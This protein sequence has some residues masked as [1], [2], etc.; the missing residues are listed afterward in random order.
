MF[1]ATNLGALE[2]YRVP[3]DWKG[4]LSD[5]DP[6]DGEALPFPRPETEAATAGDIAEIDRL[7]ELLYAQT[8]YALLI[9]L[10][11]P[12][13]S[14]KDGTIRRVFSPINP[15][16]AV[17]TSFK[18]PTPHELAHDF[19]WRIHKAVPPA[20]MIG[21][22]NRSHYEDVLVPRVHRLVPADRIEARYRQINAFEQHLSEN[23]V[24]ILKFYPHISKK[25]QKAR[26]EARLRDPTKRWKFNPDDLAERKHW[27]DYLSA[28]E[29]ALQR[30][31]T[32]WAPW[33]IVPADHKW[34]RNAVV[35]RI[36]R[37]TLEALDLTYPSEMPGLDK[38]RI[39]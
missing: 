34:Y 36:V 12:D 8:K 31:S 14:G 10:Q 3:A 38:V 30:C 33:F 37:A 24:T 23:D 20:G 32:Q 19:L 21:I 5:S 39:D 1:P 25:E 27:S 22:F 35:A 26:L 9:V 29:I 15:L 11:G 6:R 2:R 16:G 28:Y 13:T 17:A 4:K 7:Q 18:K